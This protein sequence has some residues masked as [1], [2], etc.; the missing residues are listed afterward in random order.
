MEAS[1]SL[2]RPIAPTSSGDNINAAWQF[3]N[4]EYKK[5]DASNTNT[6]NIFFRTTQERIKHIHEC[7]GT[8][9]EAVTKLY[10]VVDTVYKMLKQ[11][12]PE[13]KNNKL[14]NKVQVSEEK[15]KELI[16]TSTSK[17]R[18][19]NLF[20]HFKTYLKKTKQN[21]VCVEFLKKALRGNAEYINATEP[22][23]VILY[24][25]KKDDRIVGFLFPNFHKVTKAGRKLPII[26][27]QKLAESHSVLVEF[28]GSNTQQAKE[29]MYQLKAEIEG[30]A[31]YDQEKQIEVK[32]KMTDQPVEFKYSLDDRFSEAAR[33]QRKEVISLE[34]CQSQAK[35]ALSGLL[36]FQQ[37][38]P[39]LEP[40]GYNSIEERDIVKY[41]NWLKGVLLPA[42]EDE[43]KIIQHQER[44]LQ[45]ASK[46]DDLINEQKKPFVSVGYMLTLGDCGIY[47]L[48]KEKGYAIDQIHPRN[49]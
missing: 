28:D 47:S 1:S 34:S 43:K 21:P 46:I 40:S 41:E 19:Q 5:V 27:S 18:R 15:T 12:L 42:S 44:A 10:M 32:S 25:L 4:D 37:N 39:H 49:P 48:L 16:V 24:E 31:E 6:L 30:S 3:I 45:I 11:K 9:Y 35:I 8:D 23:S 20:D 22:S 14:K 17:T 38:Q 7:I 36:Y 33:E 13:S 26:I 2:T 29:L